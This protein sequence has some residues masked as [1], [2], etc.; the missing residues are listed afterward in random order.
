MNDRERV[1]KSRRVVVKIGSAV[2]LRGHR[3][4]DRP[5]FASL[6]EGIDGLI[7][8][9]WSVT[10]VSSGA[11]AMGKEW[12]GELAQS[13]R[14]IPLLQAYA[15]LGQARLMKMYEDEF[16]HYGRKVAQVLFSRGDL[17][18]RRR[19]LNARQTLATLEELGAVAVINENDTV[20]T[21]ELRFGDN[22]QL[23]AMTA[24]L[25]GAEVLVLLSDVEGLKE[26]EIDEGGG[27]RFGEKVDTIS[28]EDPRLD[29]WAGPSASGVGTGGMISKVKAARLAA[30]MGSVTII[31]PGKKAGVLQR[32]A[33]GEEVGTLFYPGEGRSVGGKKVWLGSGAMARGRIRCDQ[34]ARR[35][36]VERGASLL[37]SG[38]LAVEGEF[39][40]GEVVELVDEQGESF[41]RGIS[42]YS[43]EDL[44]AIAGHQS[45]EIERILGFTVLD[46]AV[47]RDNLLVF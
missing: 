5:A 35:A 3:A 32:I 34:G 15:A 9:G 11:V 39:P 43:S 38:I 10:V 18:D 4:V 44:A 21:E 47:H 17:S 23:A 19:Y 46:A 14:E 29:L 22:D 26:V 12:L 1:K 25:V 40:D 8:Q 27:R 16:A 30:R 33:L 42:V 36:V 31:A 6:V 41:A 13:R 28:V 20:A 45:E 2:F 7:Q 37:P 24:G